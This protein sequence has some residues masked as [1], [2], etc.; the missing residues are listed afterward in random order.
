MGLAKV[1][2]AA[3]AARD[4]HIKAQANNRRSYTRYQPQRNQH[5]AML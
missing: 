3:S 4:P 5:C 2:K 1:I